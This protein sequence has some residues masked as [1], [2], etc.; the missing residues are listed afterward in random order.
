MIVSVTGT[1]EEMF[2]S[3]VF[4]GMAMRMR[5]CKVRYILWRVWFI[6]NIQIP[7]QSLWRLQEGYYPNEIFGPIPARSYCL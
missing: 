1:R 2:I 4:K 7:I 6:P 3:A 5:A